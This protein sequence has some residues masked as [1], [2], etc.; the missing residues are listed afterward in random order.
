MPSSNERL[1]RWKAS[2]GGDDDGALINA[3][4]AA[5]DNDLDTPHACSQIDTAV[6]EG[7]DATSAAALLGIDLIDR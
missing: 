5:L 3:V 4:R 2:V 1:A 6:S 7:R